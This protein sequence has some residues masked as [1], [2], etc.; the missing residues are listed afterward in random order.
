MTDEIL[1]V[2]L[3]KGFKPRKAK[4]CELD[5]HLCLEDGKGNFVC[6]IPVFKKDANGEFVLF[7]FQ[8][9]KKNPRGFEI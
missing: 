8:P 2:P 1:Q 9:C 3:P 4:D 7:E 6:G 5:G